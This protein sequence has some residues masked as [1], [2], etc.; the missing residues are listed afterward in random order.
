MLSESVQWDLDVVDS[1]E[2]IAPD[3]TYMHNEVKTKKGD[4]LN[5][6]TYLAFAESIDERG[7]KKGI[8]VRIELIINEDSGLAWID[9]IGKGASRHGRQ[10]YDD[11]LPG[12]ANL[13][14]LLAQI[15]RL[16]PEIKYFAADRQ[17]GMRQKHSS[18]RPFIL[19]TSKL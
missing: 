12:Y 13:R 3:N 5:F 15:V 14:H 4:R 19:A 17:S 10:I 18:A 9:W 16:H 11:P 2:E 6:V 8:T 1:Y 7:L